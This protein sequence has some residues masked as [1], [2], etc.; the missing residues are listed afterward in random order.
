[1]E[2]LREWKNA[3]KGQNNVA[4]TCREGKTQTK[5]LKKKPVYNGESGDGGKQIGLTN[6]K[7]DW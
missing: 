7:R 1:M 6:V 3:H 5:Q 4:K 2:N